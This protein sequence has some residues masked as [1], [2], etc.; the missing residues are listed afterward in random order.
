MPIVAANFRGMPASCSRTSISKRVQKTFRTE[1]VMYLELDKREAT[2]SSYAAV[3]FDGGA[4]HDGL[5]LVNRAGSNGC[6]FR[7]TGIS[8]S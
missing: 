5:Q 1:V 7:D 2:S 6:S 3:I 8:T 4:A